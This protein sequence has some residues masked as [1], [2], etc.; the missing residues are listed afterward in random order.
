MWALF[1]FL[2]L[3]RA[4][5]LRGLPFAIS[6]TDTSIIN[7]KDFRYGTNF[8]VLSAPEHYHSSD[9]GSFKKA[10]YHGMSVTF[11]TTK[12]VDL[13]PN[14]DCA[15]PYIAD[16]MERAMVSGEVFNIF[17]YTGDITRTV[18]LLNYTIPVKIA[19]FYS[20]NGIQSN[21]KRIVFYY[22]RM[23]TDA[24]MNRCFANETL[25]MED[26]WSIVRVTADVP[27]IQAETS[28]LASFHA[29]VDRSREWT[30][31]WAWFDAYFTT[32]NL[33][34]V[35]SRS[36]ISTFRQMLTRNIIRTLATSRL[37]ELKDKPRLLTSVSSYVDKMYIYNFG[38]ASHP[39]VKSD[40]INDLYYFAFPDRSEIDEHTF[41]LNLYEHGNISFFLQNIYNYNLTIFLSELIENANVVVQ[42]A[43]NRGVI[44]LA[45]VD[46]YQVG[47]AIYITELFNKTWYIFPTT[48]PAVSLIEG[49]IPR[50]LSLATLTPTPTMSP[51][52]TPTPTLTPTPPPAYNCSAN[53]TNLVSRLFNYTTNGASLSFTPAT[54]F[55]CPTSIPDGTTLYAC[56]E[57]LAKTYILG[58]GKTPI[59]NFW[60]SLAASIRASI[61]TT[62]ITENMT[63]ALTPLIESNTVSVEQVVYFILEFANLNSTCDELIHLDV[64]TL[65]LLNTMTNLSIISPGE[66]TIMYSAISP[67]FSVVAGYR[68]LSAH[69][70][71]IITEYIGDYYDYIFTERIYLRGE[72]P[73]P[74]ADLIEDMLT[75]A[76]GKELLNLQLLTPS[77]TL[78]PSP[79]VVS[80]VEVDTAM[81]TTVYDRMLHYNGLDTVVSSERAFLMSM[82]GLCIPDLLPEM[83]D[84]IMTAFDEGTP[85]VI[86]FV[87]TSEIYG[88]SYTL[89][90]LKTWL[91]DCFTG[92]ITDP[93][94]AVRA[95][96]GATRY[97]F[98]NG[99]FGR[100]FNDGLYPFLLSDYQKE[101]ELYATGRVISSYLGSSIA[102]HLARLNAGYTINQLS[103]TAFGHGAISYYAPSL[104]AAITIAVAADPSICT[105]Y[106]CGAIINTGNATAFGNIILN[107]IWFTNSICSLGTEFADYLRFANSTH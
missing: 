3:A 101:W 9:Q 2:A 29:L 57:A 75:Y 24:I 17:V 23:T 74:K 27:C 52:Q 48:C 55:N 60:I 51:S 44:P 37:V 63:N 93:S 6:V 36:G 70:V 42:D 16:F 15:Q 32:G 79:I 47:M 54:I 103:T 89:T 92:I 97:A 59:T 61:V 98:F 66:E 21:G 40:W 20:K 58:A 25:L 41:K 88:T 26:M 73:C 8:L 11:S 86:N 78:T 72:L 64:T 4:V 46:E 68:C 14:Q 69:E 53:E 1:F 19:K 33:S 102:N 65:A 106:N 94:P 31:F 87:L 71:A 90:S 105:G 56:N 34:Y 35:A 7:V 82:S 13:F 18:T 84:S 104:V 80:C 96:K 45:L 38:S 83:W 5:T 30:V 22:V 95:A 107:Q 77:P 67:I 62:F 76:S 43:G 12:T 10:L 85:M 49:A 100:S 99:I 28:L 39:C 91:A 50:F 81:A